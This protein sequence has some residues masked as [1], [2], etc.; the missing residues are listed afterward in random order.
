MTK[1]QYKILKPYEKHFNTAKNS[2]IHGVYQSDISTLLP[3][4]ASL[5]GKLSNPNCSDCVLTM[6]RVLGREYEKYKKRYGKQ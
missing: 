4:Y 5:G 1:E 3:I 2:Y 6:F